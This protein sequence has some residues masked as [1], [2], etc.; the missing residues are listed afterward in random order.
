MEPPDAWAGTRRAPRLLALA[1]ALLLGAHPGAQAEM[2]VSVPPLVEVMR[3]ESV[4]LNCIPVG[5]HK[6]YVL[7][8]FLT[9]RTKVRRLVAEARVKGSEVQASVKDSLGRSPPYQLDAP[10]RLVLAEAQVSDELDYVCVVTAG[11]A[12]TAEATSR[13][14]V[15]AKP[16]AT[17][18]S[19]NKGIL[20]VTD[21]FAQEIATCHSRN[22]N[23]V[24]HITWYRNGEPLQVPMEMNSD[25]YITS[26]TIREASGLYSLTSTLYLRPQKAD[27]DAEFHCSAHFSLPRGQHGRLDSQVFRLTLHYPTEHVHFWVDSPATTEGWVREGD[28]VHLVCRG[29]GSSSPEYILYR[30]QDEVENTLGIDFSG[31]WTLEK[32]Q[33]NQSGIYGCRAEDFDAEDDAELSQTLE[34]HVAYL[35][36]IEFSD[37]EELS[38]TLGSTVSTNCSVQGLP[39]PALRWTKDSVPL[40]DGPTLSLSSLTFDSAGTYVCE[41]YTP[42]VPLLSRSRVLTLLV[43]G[44]PEIRQEETQPQ[45]E[46]SWREGDEV[47][48]VCFAR[49]HPEPKLSWSELGGSPTEPVPT[50][51]G[52]VSSALTVKLTHAMSKS[53]ISCEAANP[54]GNTRHVF[55]FGPLAPQTSQAGV[56]VMAVAVSVGLLLLVVAAFYC[57]RRKGRPGCCRRGEKGAPPPGD[58]E[59]SHS[60]SQPPEQTGL[61]M[62]GASG[63]ARHGSGGFGDEC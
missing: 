38:S 30:L 26:R 20:S 45:A 3:G 7:K 48:L 37:E 19:P 6:E 62:G 44:S 63:K 15:F 9:D 43:E 4:T 52:W 33:R 27:R 16:E 56:A 35:D 25:G 23:P 17:D 51:Q 57:M 13:V 18:V 10:G 42:T 2:Q 61:L 53:G 21:D 58:P 28:S 31:N 5:T 11:A 46:G 8:W 55:H 32:V 1:L 24:S 47:R 34:L 36:P 22:G 39:A 29:D 49:G 50:R 14:L 54:H 60:G 59:L 41:A 40:G 12:G